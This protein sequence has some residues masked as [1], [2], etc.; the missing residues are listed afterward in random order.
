M[1][2]VLIS[3]IGALLFINDA[4]AAEKQEIAKCAAK[5]SDAARLVCYDTLARSLGVEKPKSSISHGVGKWNTRVDRSPI[6]DSENVYLTVEAEEIVHSGYK[7]VKPTL[8]VRC[9]EK[10]TNVFITWDLYLGL[11]STQMLSRFDTA[12][13][14]TGTWSISTDNT[15]V[16]AQGSDIAFAKKMMGHEKLLTQITPYGES[17]VMATFKIAGLTDAIKPLRKA[18]GW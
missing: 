14:T 10:K 7:T 4:V 2:Y 15:A 18:C 1:K 3:F 13:A 9:S 16:F 11:E 12:K 6:D 8:Y 5:D 17:P